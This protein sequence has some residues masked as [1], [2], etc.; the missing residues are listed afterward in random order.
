MQLTRAG[1]FAGG[2]AVV[3]ASV[4]GTVAGQPGGRKVF[5]NSVVPLTEGATLGPHGLVVN[6]AGDA[7]K[8]DKMDVLFSLG[9]PKEARAQLE[10]KVLK[11]EVVTAETL[12]RDYSPK[13]AD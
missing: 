4:L 12:A 2:L 5:T 8:Q 9:I 10:A 6:A 13:Q 3:V 7:H 11:G 1:V